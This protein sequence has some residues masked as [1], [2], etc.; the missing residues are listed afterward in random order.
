[1]TAAVISGALADRLAKLCGMFSSNFDGERAT[2]ARM[3]DEMVRNAGLSWPDVISICP[4][5]SIPN[6]RVWREPTTIREFN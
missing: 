2:A 6:Y 1:M 4:A 3:A 5:G